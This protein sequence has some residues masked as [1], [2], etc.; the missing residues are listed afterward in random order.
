MKNLAGDPKCDAEIRRE[1]TR[2]RIPIVATSSRGEVPA[3]IAGEL[4]PFKFRRAW[5]YWV[6]DGPVPLDVARELYADPVGATDVR[7]AGHCG[8]PP[9][10][11]W[12]T[13]FDAAGL[14]LCSDPDGEEEATFDGM[15]ERGLLSADQKSR[16]R[17]VP[18][19]VAASVRAVVQNYHIDTEVGLRLFVDTIRRA[20]LEG[21]GAAPPGRS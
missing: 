12:A 13:Y 9:P 21:A 7:V 10:D 2:A 15:I 19:R 3:S 5:Y 1:L 11:E 16:F 4:G 17:Y 14:E 8:C 20:A 18:D 6:V